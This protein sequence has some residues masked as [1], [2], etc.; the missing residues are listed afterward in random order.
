M[1]TVQRHIKDLCRRQCFDVFASGDDTEAPYYR[2]DD[3]IEVTLPEARRK[4]PDPQSLM[5][6]DLF[7][8]Y[9]LRPRCSEIKQ[10]ILR[11]ALM[12]VTSFNTTFVHPASQS[13][14]KLPS[15]II[16]FFFFNVY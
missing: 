14:K 2:V 10:P 9:L 13:I 5:R 8:T 11:E 3:L 16:I 6:L 12:K 4:N 15:S 1:D 7:I